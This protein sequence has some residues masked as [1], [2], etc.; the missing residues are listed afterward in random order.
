MLRPETSN[1]RPQQNHIIPSKYSLLGAR[2]AK[3]ARAQ[4]HMFVCEHRFVLMFRADGDGVETLRDSKG[5]K[6]FGLP[7][8]MQEFLHTMGCE[9]K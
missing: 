1:G 4:K 5:C 6:E 7:R 2:L 9:A 3:L 8:C